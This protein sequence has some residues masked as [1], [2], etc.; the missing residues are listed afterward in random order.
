MKLKE[1]Q[2]AKKAAGGAIPAD[3]SKNVKEQKKPENKPP[4]PPK[5]QSQ[6]AQQTAPKQDDDDSAFQAPS[7]DASVTKLTTNLKSSLK[8]SSTST[9]AESQKEIQFETSSVTLKLTKKKPDSNEDLSASYK[10]RLFHHFDQYKRDYSITEKLG[11][12]NTSIHPAFI[13]LGIQ[14]AHDC[15]SGSNARCIAFLKTFKQFIND[16]K[17]PNRETK[18]ISKDLESKLKPNI[19]YLYSLMLNLGMKKNLILIITKYKVSKNA[20]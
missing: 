12:D 16:Y 17:A 11:M 6:P 19:K 5:P 1:A 2:R 20:F 14:S 9:G 15:I 18:T 3:A 4:P 7:S 10:S 8:I 13:R